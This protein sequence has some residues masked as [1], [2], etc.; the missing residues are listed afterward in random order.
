MNAQKR[1][2]LEAGQSARQIA[3]HWEAEEAAF[4]EAWLEISYGREMRTVSLG[5]TPVSIGSDHKLS[6]V[7]ARGAA[8]VAFR[9]RIAERKIECEDVVVGRTEIVAD[10]RY[11]LLGLRVARDLFPN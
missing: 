7:Y 9:Y 8:P 6:S 2:A 11:S 4:R 5:A 1:Q 10:D 3:R